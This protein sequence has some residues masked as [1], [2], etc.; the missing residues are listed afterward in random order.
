MSRPPRLA[1][2]KTRWSATV[3]RRKQLWRWSMRSRCFSPSVH[4]IPSE[5]PTCPSHLTPT[6]T[7]SPVFSNHPVSYLYQP[8]FPVPVSETWICTCLP[9]CTFNL[10]HLVNLP[11]LSGLAAFNFMYY[12]LLK[13]LFQSAWVKDF[14]L[15]LGEG[16]HIYNG[17]TGVRPPGNFEHHTPNFLHSG[18]FLCINLRWKSLYLSKGKHKVFQTAAV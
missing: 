9:S 1:E 17:G 5:F 8:L 15:T 6:S 2:T 4:Q 18:E 14:V 7:C 16:G 12:C 11:L 13:S 10:S 3:W